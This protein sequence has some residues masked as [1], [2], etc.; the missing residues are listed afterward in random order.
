MDKKIGVLI[1]LVLLGLYFSFAVTA[2]VDV[3][4]LE[5]NVDDL[6]KTVDGIRDVTEKE[7]W[8]YLGEQWK[9]II[10][11]NDKVDRFNSL[12]D[13]FDP[14]FFF[15]FGEEY[16][17]SLTLLFIV[18]LWVAFLIIFHEVFMLYG[19]FSNN[20]SWAVSFIFSVVLAH[21]RVNDGISLVLFKIIFFRDG[22][23][24]WV[25]FFVFIVAY[26]IILLYLKQLSKK[27]KKENEESKL[28]AEK[29]QAKFDREII[30]QTAEAV[31]EGLGAK[32]ASTWE[33]FSN[34]MKGSK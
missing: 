7:K 29:K 33:W 5:D 13:K 34:W 4:S 32:E 26:I 9:E 27:M 14:V 18:L 25:A 10:L 19:T 12:L 17:L 3:N 16:D 31:T 24:G 1:L 23:W 11:K 8:D 28:E 20:I 2:Q 6:E 22:I 15:L 30:H 21:L